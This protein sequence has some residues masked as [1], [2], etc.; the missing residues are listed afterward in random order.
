MHRN[1]SSF[2]NFVE[3]TVQ[4]HF[5]YS[6]THRPYG[7]TTERMI[8]ERRRSMITLTELGQS[9]Y[10][11][12]VGIPIPKRRPSCC[13][14]T[15]TPTSPTSVF[16]YHPYSSQSP[17]SRVPETQSKI[18]PTSNNRRRIKLLRS[19][20]APQT[21]KLAP[22]RRPSTTAYLSP[23]LGAL[24]RPGN[25]IDAS[26]YESIPDSPA[27]HVIPLIRDCRSLG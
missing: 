7:K 15:L 26:S 14:T 6:L 19:S 20:V 23:A 11:S 17:S 13:Y 10:T 4:P 1:R 18:W 8:P 5:L 3:R 22:T 12:G 25:F 16:S 21:N 9:M 2:S 27:K 24:S